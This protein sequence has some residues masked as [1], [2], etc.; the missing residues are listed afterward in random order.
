MSVITRLQNSFGFTRNEITVILFLS[1][2]FLA[3]LGVKW[4]NASD[5]QGAFAEVPFD[6]T[7]SDSVFLERSKRLNIREQPAQPADPKPRNTAKAGVLQPA[8][9]NIN[10]ASKEEL[11][12]LPGIGEGYAERIILYREDNGPFATVEDLVNVKGIGKK[13]L[14]KIRPFV[15][16]R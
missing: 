12:L 9:I 3:G 2:T 1:C 14:E 7:A 5:R 4:Y 10:T 11:M 6:Y 15:A 16:V 8:G 13:T